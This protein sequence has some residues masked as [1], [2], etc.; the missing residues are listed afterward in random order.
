MEV[1]CQYC[2]NKAESVDGSVIYPHRPDLSNL[3]FFQCKSCDAYVGCHK[4]TGEPFGTLADKDTRKARKSA[5][6][7]FDPFWRKRG[8][9]RREAYKLL[10]EHMGLPVE[11]THIGNFDVEQCKRVMMFN[12]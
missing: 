12:I 3:K 10:S 2:G 1:V 8:V 4:E 6:K 7:H 5:H 11:K 9:S